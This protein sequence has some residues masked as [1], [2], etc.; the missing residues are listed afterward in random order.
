MHRTRAERRHNDWVKIRRKANIVKGF[1]REWYDHY[2]AG[3]EH[4]LSK[5]KIHCSCPLCAA[6]TRIHGPT[7]SDYKQFERLQS[8]LDEAEFNMRI[9]P[10]K[11]W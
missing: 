6:K 7:L 8:S 10:H 3:Q 2:W 9:L 1:D 11:G 5:S 4:R